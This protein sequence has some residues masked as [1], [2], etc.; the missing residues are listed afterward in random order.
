MDKSNE[1][2]NSMLIFLD[3]TIGFRRSLHFLHRWYES[4][5]QEDLI[6]LIVE[7]GKEHYIDLWPLVNWCQG[8]GDDIDQTVHN[9]FLKHIHL[10]KEL[11][12]KQDIM[13][14]PVPPWLILGLSP[15]PPWSMQ[16][17]HL[18]YGSNIGMQADRF[19]DL[20]DWIYENSKLFDNPLSVIPHVLD[21]IKESK[22]DIT[23]LIEVMKIFLG[24]TLLSCLDDESMFIAEVAKYYPWRAE[25]ISLLAQTIEENLDLNWKDALSRN[26]IQSKF[27]LIEKMKE[28]G[29]TG[30]SQIKD[31]ILDPQ[32]FVVVGGWVG[33]LPWIMELSKDF[34][35]YKLI[36]PPNLINIDIDPNVHLAADKLLAGVTKFNYSGV[37]RDIKKYN[38][39]Q[40]KN[41]IVI[42]TIVEHF[43][44]HG[45]WVQSLPKGTLVV[46]QGN[47][48]F[49]EPDHVNCH[50]SLEEFVEASGLNTI[51]WSGELILHKC[52]RFMAI[53]TV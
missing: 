53:G 11:T 46:L 34:E 23:K 28:C 33:I 49:D 38:F 41:L 40:H 4:Q 21:L 44:N 9:L 52:L 45:K 30:K 3:E 42:D 32:T 17:V 37:A 31:N 15:V 18:T 36:H 24:D 20:H 35:P 16:Q 43:R 1:L 51:I 6:K 8:K 26:Q 12:D 2:K 50:N 47:N 13:L 25:Q 10:S 39:T 27:W 19:W 5:D 48:M 14:S 7:I 22:E 29:A